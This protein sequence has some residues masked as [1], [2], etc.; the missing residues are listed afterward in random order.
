MGKRYLCPQHIHHLKTQGKSIELSTEKCSVCRWE[1]RPWTLKDFAVEFK[2]ISENLLF[3]H[4]NPDYDPFGITFMGDIEKT[5]KG[6]IKSIHP[7]YRKNFL[8]ALNDDSN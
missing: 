8:K 5:V 4:D 1:K 6:F 2:N 7:D 3:A